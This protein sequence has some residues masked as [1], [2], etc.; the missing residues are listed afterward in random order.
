MTPENRL[1]KQALQLV[2]ERACQGVTI[3]EILEVVPVSRKTLERQFLVHLG[4]TPGQEVARV[5][6]EKAKTLLAT[7]HLPM[8]NIAQMLGF[9]KASHFGDF[10]RHHMR[11][12]PSAFRRMNQSLTISQIISHV[13]SP[14]PAQFTNMDETF[15]VRGNHS[16]QNVMK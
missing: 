4:R 6:L 7:S 11:Q 12:S 8:K 10:F 2:Q 3:E 1:Y 15:A 16:M 5:R 9:D 14:V 13:S